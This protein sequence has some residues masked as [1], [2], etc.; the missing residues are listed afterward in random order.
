MI[1][2]HGDT[3]GGGAMMF[4]H[5]GRRAIKLIDQPIGG[6]QGQADFFGNGCRLDD[7]FGLVDIESIGDHDKFVAAKAGDGVHFADAAFQPV[8]HFSQQQIANVMAVRIV[9]RFEVVEV[10]KEQRAVTGAALARC[11]RLAQPVGKQATVRQPGERIEERQLPHL[12]FHPLVLVD[13]GVNADHAGGVV[14]GIPLHDFPHR[15]QPFPLTGTALSPVFHRRRI[16]VGEAVPKRGSKGFSVIG[17]HLIQPAGQ[18]GLEPR[19]VVA[20]HRSIF[21]T[22]HH[23]VGKEINVKPGLICRAEREPQPFL[24]FLQ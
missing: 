5:A 8:C 13:V 17:V 2:K 16:A 23:P 19:R 21:R 18:A 7:R 6:R 20:Q 4:D 1:Q 22:D 9:E 15:T 11:H 14:C 3:D 24:A 10:N 12:V